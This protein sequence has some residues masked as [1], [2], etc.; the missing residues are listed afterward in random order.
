MPKSYASSLSRRA[1]WPLAML[2]A[3]LLGPVAHGQTWSWFV[4]PFSV[5]M[6]M[7]SPEFGRSDGALYVERADVR[8]EMSMV[9]MTQVMLLRLLEDGVLLRVLLPDG[10]YVEQHHGLGDLPEVV[11]QGYVAAVTAP[12]DPRHPCVR[13]PE[14]HRCTLVGEEPV[15]GRPVERW[16]LDAEDGDGSSHGQYFLFDRTAGFVIGAEDDT[17][18]V[19]TYAG[20]DAAPQPAELFEVP[21]G[22]VPVDLPLVPPIR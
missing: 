16:R 15:D 12:D 13:S 7:V 9:G 5:E 21:E 6:V 11:V 1:G 22:Y 4:E 19:I 2:V 18:V 17:G 10:S 3:A 20:H 8:L 14:V